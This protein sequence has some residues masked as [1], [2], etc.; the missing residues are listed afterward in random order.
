M[1]GSVGKLMGADPALRSYHPH[2]C[3][4]LIHSLWALLGAPQHP[5]QW[6]EA[7]SCLLGFLNFN[8]HLGLQKVSGTGS[9]EA[10]SEG[11]GIQNLCPVLRIFPPG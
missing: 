10:D 1:L 3:L 11:P 9:L 2:S 8:V 7:R 4:P 5:R 6:Q